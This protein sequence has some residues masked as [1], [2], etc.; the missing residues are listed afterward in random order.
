MDNA[1]NLVKNCVVKVSTQNE[2]IN[3]S[4]VLETF[5]GYIEW[6]CEDHFC[7]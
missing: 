2:L 3:K 6:L 5:Y 4:E 1:E 7:K